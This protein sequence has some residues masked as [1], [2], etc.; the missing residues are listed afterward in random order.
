MIISIKITINIE[1][2]KFSFSV[3]INHCT[4]LDLTLKLSRFGSYNTKASINTKVWGPSRLH[5]E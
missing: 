1:N 5:K 3:S 2:F 4:L